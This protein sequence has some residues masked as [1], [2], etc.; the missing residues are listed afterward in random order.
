MA[1]FYGTDHLPLF[2]RPVLTIGTF[3]GV[4]KGHKAILADVVAQAGAIGG[5]SILITFE[6]HP[7]KLI[8][9]DQSL[10]LLTTL[11]DRIALILANGIDNVVV[12]PFNA[13][14]AAL[15]AVAYIRDFLVAKFRPEAI[16]I[17]YDHHFGHDRTGDLALLQSS[18]AAF[19][20]TVYELPAQKIADAAVSSTKIRK[21][22]L[23]GDV[24]AATMMLGR[25][26][27]LTGKVVHGAKLGRTLGYPTANILPADADQLIP[28]NGV[29]AVMAEV[30]GR[31][32]GGMLNI[33]IR[34]TVS[35]E[36]ALHIEAHLF[37]F[38]ADIYGDDL[39]LSFI[40]RL[41]DEQKFPSLDALKAQLDADADA[42]KNI[43]RK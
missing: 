36:L 29:Y 13:A 27:M 22:L 11:D 6:P 43:L 37:D 33:G 25:P 16:V 20:F 40:A 39:T 17:G 5:E 8:Y 7:R 28:A 19:D 32:H 26:Y 30:N 34:P 24:A 14:F 15:S 18:G 2:T 4:H 9:P 10:Q 38:A 41:R 23:G 21:A 3:D 12:A 35:A 42:A 1:V 31:D